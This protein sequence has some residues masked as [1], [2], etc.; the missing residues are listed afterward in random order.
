MSGRHRPQGWN[1]LRLGTNRTLEYADLPLWWRSMFLI[2][3]VLV[4]IG[5]GGV[6]TS[7]LQAA[8]VLSAGIV[9]TGLAV[10]FRYWRRR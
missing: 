3:A 4:A 5:L 10:W 2:G 1:R 8:A 6:G 7:A 9:V